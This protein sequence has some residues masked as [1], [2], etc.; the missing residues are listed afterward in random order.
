MKP[1]C[2]QGASHGSVVPSGFIMSGLREFLFIKN[3]IILNYFRY[4]ERNFIDSAIITAF[5]GEE[6][7]SQEFILETLLKIAGLLDFSDEVGR[8]VIEER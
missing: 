8:Y 7:S 4:A 2:V 3:F 6:N 5:D 1:L